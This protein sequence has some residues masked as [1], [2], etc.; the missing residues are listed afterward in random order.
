MNKTGI[1][2]IVAFSLI[3]FGSLLA[4]FVQSNAGSDDVIVG[5]Q[6]SRNGNEIVLITEQGRM[7]LTSDRIEL[8]ISRRR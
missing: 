8:A 5:H 2:F 4:H 7:K 3:L 6:V 1:Q